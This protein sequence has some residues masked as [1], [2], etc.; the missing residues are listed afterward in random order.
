M[1]RLLTSLACFVFLGALPGVAFDFEQ[2]MA[3]LNRAR[4]L[5]N[6]VRAEATLDLRLDP[7]DVEKVLWL[8]DQLDWSSNQLES[9]IDRVKQ[10]SLTPPLEAEWDREYAHFQDLTRQLE[11]TT[12][13]VSEKI[14]R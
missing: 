2:S 11:S 8:C 5:C 12:A 9:T 7:A 6:E 14:P 13:I 4:D 1:K 3:Q 10:N